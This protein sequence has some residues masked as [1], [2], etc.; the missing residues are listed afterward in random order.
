M[1]QHRLV[2]E[3][4]LGRFLTKPERVHHLN[5]LRW[6]NRIENLQLHANHSEH[7]RDHWKDSPRNDPKLIEL[8]KQYAP[9]PSKQL[10]D[11]PAAAGTVYAICRSLGIRWVRGYKRKVPD[12]PTM[13]EALQRMTTREAAAHFGISFQTMHVR[14]G[15]LLKKRA[16]PNCLLP[17]RDEI[18]R[19]VL[20]ERR[21]HAEIGRMYGVSDMCV[22][23]SIQ[24]WRATGAIPGASARRYRKKRERMAQGTAQPSPSPGAAPQAS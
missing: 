23:R 20:K 7:M 18:L 8:V 9:D 16:S 10:S 5:H 17:H 13:R 12:E 3:C 24:R 14:F 21:T 4:H 2:M 6:D 1:L 22:H 19:L 11:V 15:H